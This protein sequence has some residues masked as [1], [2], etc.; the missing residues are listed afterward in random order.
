MARSEVSYTVQL[1]QTLDRLAHGGLLLAST[2][3][4]GRSNVMTIGWA[5]VGVVWG[6][7]MMVVLVRPSRYTYGFVEE[8]GLF[9]VNVPPPEMT[10][11]VAF[12]GTK[13]GRDVYKLAQTPTSM[14]TR[15]DCVT[16]DACP[17]VYECQVVHRNDVQPD[18]LRPSID[19]KAYAQGDYHRL[20]YGQILG[21]FGQ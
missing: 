17:L 16:M 13:S 11:S 2:R 14:G 9:T 21:T 7:P 18:V 15:I 8:S 12:C 1:D 3:S 6:L 4:D 5:T 20:Y 10:Q 19:Q